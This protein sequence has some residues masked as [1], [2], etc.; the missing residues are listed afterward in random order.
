MIS[1][2]GTLTLIIEKLGKKKKMQ[3]SSMM[4]SDMGLKYDSAM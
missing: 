2:P 4:Q 3:N 1:Y